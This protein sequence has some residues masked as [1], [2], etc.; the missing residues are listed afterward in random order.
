MADAIPT[1]RAQLRKSFSDFLTRQREAAGALRDVVR[2]HKW[3]A[4]VFGGTPRGI[5]ED[6]PSYR[7]R[8]LDLVFDDAHFEEF[9]SMFS[10][11]VT[12]R[13][14]FGGVHLRMMNL[15]VDAWPLSST[16]AFREGLIRDVSFEALPRTTFFNA[17]AIVISLTP[18]PRAREFYEAGFQR[19]WEEGLLDINLEQNPFPALCVVRAFR[20]ASSF[21]FYFSPRLVEYLAKNFQ[22]LS[23]EELTNVQESHYG[24]VHFSPPRLMQLRQSTISHWLKTPLLPLQPFPGQL[25]FPFRGIGTREDHAPVSSRRFAA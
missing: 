9:V 1:I 17:D 10:R 12:R 5:L 2:E 19:A 6:G 8:D 22:T 14:R 7:P 20:L 25:R 18:Q 23:N 24:T 3:K 21:R 15:E 4:F 16:W 11:N 13:T